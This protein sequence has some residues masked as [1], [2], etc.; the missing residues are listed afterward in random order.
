MNSKNDDYISYCPNLSGAKKLGITKIYI[1]KHCGGYKQG[2]HEYKAI[3]PD[4]SIEYN[5]TINGNLL[6]LEN[7]KKFKIKP[8]YEKHL[9]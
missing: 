1:L 2:G 6:G 5:N 4:E 9:N 8:W 7:F 3:L